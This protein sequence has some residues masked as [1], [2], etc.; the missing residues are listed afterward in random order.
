MFIPGFVTA[1]QHHG[2]AERIKG[3][4]YLV[5]FAFMLSPQPFFECFFS[6]P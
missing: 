5:W 2:L 3:E 6:G 4:N 1:T